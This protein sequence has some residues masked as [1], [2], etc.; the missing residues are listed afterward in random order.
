MYIYYTPIA[1]AFVSILV[2]I[3]NDRRAD[4][5]LLMVIAIFVVTV[6]GFRYF[7][8]VDYEPYFDLYK[9]TPT[10]ADFEKEDMRLLYGEPGYLLLSRTI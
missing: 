1:I 2:N 10:I 9:Q 3:S 6:S 8:D 7:S 5:S 4:V